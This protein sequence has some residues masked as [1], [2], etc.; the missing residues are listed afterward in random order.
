MEPSQITSNVFAP[1]SRP[2]VFARLFTETNTPHRFDREHNE[3]PI[4]GRCG[5]FE[6]G[7]LATCPIQHMSYEEGQIAYAAYGDRCDL[8]REEAAVRKM[9]E[10]DDS[11]EDGQ[12]A[13]SRPYFRFQPTIAEYNARARAYNDALLDEAI[14]TLNLT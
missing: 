10:Q 9:T 11:D 6:G 2:R 13:G 7:L 4:C 3:L 5:G 8:F 1:R 14:P 12:Y